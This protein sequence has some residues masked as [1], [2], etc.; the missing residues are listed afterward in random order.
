VLSPYNKP[1]IL[2]LLQSSTPF[3]RAHLDNRSPYGFDTTPIRHEIAA[4]DIFS[5]HASPITPLQPPF[6]VQK[7]VF[8]NDVGQFIHP[9]VTSPRSKHIDSPD[10]GRPNRIPTDRRS[11]DTPFE[12][13][14]GAHPASPSTRRARS[15]R[16]RRAARVRLRSVYGHAPR[17]R[18]HGAHRAMRPSILQGLRPRAYHVADGIATFPSSVPDMYRRSWELPGINRE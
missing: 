18:I 2:L 7:I 14:G 9:S 4:C 10:P 3:Q 1:L 8:W 5:Q 17:R 15:T 12:R 6:V 11:T 13:Q 16:N